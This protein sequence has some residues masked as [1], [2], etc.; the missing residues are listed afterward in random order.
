[1]TE[2]KETRVWVDGCFD[3]MHFG[4]ANALRQAKMMGDCLI[5]GVHNDEEILKHKGPSV[6]NEEE[7]YRAV[8][9]CKWVDEVVR[10]A[11]Y[12]TT[13]KTLDEYGCGFCVH[14]DDITTMADGVDCYQEVKL[15]GRYKEFQRTV[16]ISTTRLVGRMLLMTKEHHIKIDLSRDIIQLDKIEY[17]NYF[18]RGF[19]H[20]NLD[21]TLSQYL[22]STH[23]LFP[24]STGKKPKPDDRVI[25]VDGD[26]DLFHIGHVEFLKSA[27]EM[28]TY[29]LVGI[30]DDMTVNK[31]K[32]GNFPITNLHE[33]ILN[34]LSCRYIDE[35]IIG[36]PYTINSDFFHKI[37]KLSLVIHGNNPILLD[38]NQQDPYHLPKELNIF[39]IV[40]TPFS[41]I[42][43]EGILERIISHRKEYE[44][45]NRNKEIRELENLKLKA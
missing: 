3:M 21:I 8:A 22:L 41:H 20:P 18:I 36:A 25:Y 16:G 24:H 33:R 2:R 32:G 40:E 15:H 28:G 35:I 4:H 31:I 5:V 9:A 6:M 17:L 19:H 11:P 13:I 14:G 10:D 45:R 42:T 30:H 34:L 27:K 7:R 38:E 23:Q 1:M 43:S 37:H 12:Y 26:F 44:I 39:K 29:L